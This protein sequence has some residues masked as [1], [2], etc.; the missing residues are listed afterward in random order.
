MSRKDRVRNPKYAYGY[1]VYDWR[2]QK[3]ICVNCGIERAC[4]GIILCPD[5]WE[6]S[7]LRNRKYYETHKEEVLK[8]NRIN[9]KKLYWYR[10]ENGLCTK[11][12]HKAVKDKSLCLSCI[13]KKRRKKDPRWNNDLDRNERPSYGLCY[14]CAKPLNK[15]EKLCDECYEKAKEKMLQLNANPTEAMLKVR[16]RKKREIDAFWRKLKGE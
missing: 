14:V 5:C 1:E 3:G 16:E 11:C 7:N 6:K 2:K 4:I 12:G 8:N 9:G 10:R 15:Y 13:T